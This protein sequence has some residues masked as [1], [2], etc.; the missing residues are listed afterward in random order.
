MLRTLVASPLTTIAHAPVPKVLCLVAAEGHSEAQVEFLAHLA[1]PQAV[2]APQAARAPSREP[3]PECPK[4]SE[5]QTAGQ[6]GRQG[7][8]DGEGKE[9]ERD[10]DND[11]DYKKEE[12]DEEEEG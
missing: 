6:C 10:R 9:G 12:K 2:A 1:T 8:K 7:R 4:Q 3:Q 5:G 11:G